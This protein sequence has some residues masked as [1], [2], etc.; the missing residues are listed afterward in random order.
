VRRGT[1]PPLAIANP[2]DA[3]RA[4]I[5][6]VPEDRQQQ[7]LLLPQPLRANLTLASLPSFARPWLVD[8]EREARAAEEIRAGLEVHSQSI[9]QPAAELSGGNQQKL[10]IGRWLLRDCDVLLFDEPTRG[11]DVA[12]KIAVYNVLHGL[13]ARGKA[14]VIVSSELPELMALCDR[15]AVMSAGRLV[16]TFTRGAW[17][18]EA[19]VAASFSEHAG[20]AH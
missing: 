11:I 15:I 13:S 20:R 2:R 12:A 16:N 18:E 17:S 5:G 10:V 6:M 8:A 7:G 4:G 9:E 14:I 3:V 1:G 19:I